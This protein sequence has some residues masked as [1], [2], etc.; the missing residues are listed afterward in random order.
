MFTDFNDINRMFGAMDLLRHRMDR[1]F[2]DFDPSSDRIPDVSWWSNFPRTNL[3]ENGDYFELQAEVPGLSKD[4]LTLNIQGNYLEISGKR[5]ITSP[6]G[7]KTHRRERSDQ[8]FSR[9]YTLPADVETDSVDATLKD[10]ILTLK[11]PKTPDAK[12]KKVTIS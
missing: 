9:S 5:S 4:D 2:N 11:L 1:F 7:V 8:A 6:E 12:P 10:G 3:F